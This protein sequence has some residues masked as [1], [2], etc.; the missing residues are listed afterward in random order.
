MASGLP[1]PGPS[2][3]VR[4]PAP[5]SP[6]PRPIDHAKSI[7]WLRPSLHV[8]AA[9][10]QPV[11]P[12]VVVERLVLGQLD[13]GA[14]QADALAV[15]AGKVG[16]AADPGGVAA[17]ERVIPDVQLPD[18]RRVDGR[19]EIARRRGRRRRCIRWRRC[20][21]TAACRR[22]AACWPALAVPSRCARS[23]PR[24]PALAPLQHRQVPTRPLFDA[25]R[26]GI[27]VLGQP[28]QA[29]VAGVRAGK[30]R[31]FDVVAHQVVGRRELV[32]SCPRRTASGSTSRAPRRA[33]SRRSGLRPGCGA[34]CRPAARPRPATRNGRSR[35][36][37]CDDRR[38]TS[39]ESASL[40]Q[41]LSW[42]DS[43]CV[44]AVGHC[45]RRGPARDTPGR[46]RR[47]RGTCRAAAAPSRRYGDRSARERKDRGPAGGPARG[48]RGPSRR[49]RQTGRSWGGH[50][51][52]GLPVSTSTAGWQ[53]EQHVDLV[54]EAQVLRALADVERQ[55]GLALAGVAAVEL[56]DAIFQ[57]Q[58]RQVL[59]QRLA[60]VRSR[61]PASGRPRRW[62]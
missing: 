58:A 28:Q 50:R 20:R 47:S 22:S 30:A 44:T 31:D 39:P 14:A 55:L 56:D 17:V 35:R 62:R 40:I 46:G 9:V 43:L 1:R 45:D 3:L 51:R 59:V 29:Q 61:R 16:L 7:R 23:R 15:D 12:A 4:P 21:R 60:V 26:A 25:G 41:R 5:F 11:D 48:R 57:L 34:S 49:E 53:L 6:T 36:R 38:K 32:D 54:A 19:D 52:R 13:V 27:V 37:G 10:A 33:R 24:R 18:G 42:N 2:T 8:A